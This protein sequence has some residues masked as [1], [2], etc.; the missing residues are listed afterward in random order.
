MSKTDSKKRLYTEENSKIAAYLQGDP[1]EIHI[2]NRF[3]KIIAP[4]LMQLAGFIARVGWRPKNKLE[5]SLTEPLIVPSK[6]YY[7]NLDLK[8][9]YLL[10][11]NKSNT[12]L[13][14][15]LA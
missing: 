10:D 13:N 12:Y 5:I 4:G 11:E 3:G 1:N 14:N 15:F 6:A 9:H 2:N 7:D 8:N